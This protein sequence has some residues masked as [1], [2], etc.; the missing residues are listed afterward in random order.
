MA[1]I[2]LRYLGSFQKGIHVESEQPR[3]EIWSRLALYGSDQFVDE[4]LTITKGSINKK[5]LVEYVAVR[6][7]QA[8]E[9]RTA[10]HQATLL[11][12]PLALYYSFLNL[13]RACMGILEEKTSTGHGLKF[14]QEPKILDSKAELISGTFT[15]YLAANGVPFKPGVTISLEDCLSRV[16]E[17]SA[18]YFTVAGKPPHA[19]PVHVEVLRSG[20]VHLHLRDDWTGGESH[21]RTRWKDEY[22][23]L[24]S[25]FELEPSG[26]VLRVKKSEEP[27]SLEEVAKLCAKTLEI[28][29]IPSQ[30]PLWFIVRQTPS[31]FLWNRPA[32]Y[33]VAL[34]ILSSI[35]RYQ[36]ELMFQVTSQYSK[37]G[38]FLQRFISSAERFYPHFMYNWIQNTVF[39][40]G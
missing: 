7:R 35:V 11:T 9:L 25:F 29:L 20:R 34:F 10:T 39:F 4:N 32:Y 16:I 38:W 13:T 19:I 23:S 27:N 30:D 40:F 24:A 36:P 6:T 15:D 12:S 18:D 22:P 3:A 31:D 21:F 1:L 2:G 37:W 28:N 26:C 14:K 5:E 33:L 17:T 8:V